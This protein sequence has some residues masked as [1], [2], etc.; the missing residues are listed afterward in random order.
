MTLFSA[1]G[2]LAFIVMLLGAGSLLAATE[3]TVRTLPADA[4][5]TL[6]V[7]M[8]D[9]GVTVR[10][11]ERDEIEIVTVKSGANRDH[12]EAL[13]SKIETRGD[14]VAIT[15]RRP[16][17]HLT[18]AARQARID[19]EIRVPARLASCRIDLDVGDVT[20]EGL[21]GEVRVR[22]D[23]AQVK[24]HSLRGNL[25]ARVSI[26]QIDV[27][28]AALGADQS[29]E[30]RTSNGSIKFRVPA[31]ADAR[32]D[33]LARLG[34]IITDIPVQVLK[35][36]HLVDQELVGGWGRRSGSVVLR[37]KLGSIRLAAADPVRQSAAADSL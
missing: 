4:D 32:L 36:D 30:L 16:L 9:G 7:R 35:S 14:E 25:D 18:K 34:E 29:V 19:Y 28:F 24:G 20:L 2:R 15:A 3:R 37:S 31:E 12:L 8:K 33:A 27:G 13:D 1:L 10:T 23:I 17:V 22:G 21:S 6:R 26:G 5:T 11:W